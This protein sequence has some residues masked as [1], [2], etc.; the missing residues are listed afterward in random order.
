MRVIV[1]HEFG[2]LDVEASTL[3]PV[4]TVQNFGISFDPE[5]S[6][7]KEIDTVVKN[8][9]F[10]IH[11]IY[12]IRKFLDRKCLQVLVHSLVIP[13]I[14]YCNSLY[15][16]LS[17]YVLRKLQS[18]ANRSARLIYSLPPSVP[19]TSSSYLTELHWLSVKA[20]IEFKICVLAFEALKL[21]KPKYLADFLNLQ[22]VHMGMG[23]RTSDD[24]F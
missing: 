24:P 4:D 5:P 20:R 7:N 23:L 19:T 21:G 11:N 2:N 17:N 3:A 14:D 9:N 8:S 16:S 13:K 15:V 10:R 6:F 1:T 12:A 18:V 22:N